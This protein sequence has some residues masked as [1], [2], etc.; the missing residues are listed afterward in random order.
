M[1]IQNKADIGNLAFLRTQRGRGR[2]GREYVQARLV[3]ASPTASRVIILGIFYLLQPVASK[4]GGSGPGCYTT[5]MPAVGDR[6]A[7]F[8][9]RLRVDSVKQRTPIHQ[10][11]RD[12]LHLPDV[13]REGDMLSKGAS[14]T[15]IAR[16]SLLPGL[17]ESSLRR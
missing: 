17:P 4:Q 9:S 2:N 7:L 3:R 12:T 6:W 11:D 8:L 13:I 1:S 15:L 5:R 10:P 16:S 14:S